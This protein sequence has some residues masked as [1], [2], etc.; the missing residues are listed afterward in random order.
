MHWVPIL[1][2]QFDGTRPR[3]HVLHLLYEVEV[4]GIMDEVIDLNQ[5]PIRLDEGM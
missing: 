3:E 2:E 4:Y 5:L 1:D